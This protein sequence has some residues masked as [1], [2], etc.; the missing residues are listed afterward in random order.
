MQ[1]TFEGLLRPQKLAF[2]MENILKEVLI[3]NCRDKT[4][5]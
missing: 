3:Q 4:V 5:G 1:S 2:L